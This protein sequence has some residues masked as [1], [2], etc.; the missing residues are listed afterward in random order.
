MVGLHIGWAI[1]I[2]ISLF[3]FSVLVGRW[4]YGA[5][6]LFEKCANF[7]VYKGPFWLN[8]GRGRYLVRYTSK[9]GT[10]K[11]TVDI[12]ELVTKGDGI[13]TGPL[14]AFHAYSAVWR[15]T[16]TRAGR[17]CPRRTIYNFVFGN[18]S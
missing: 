18:R 10:A 9:R 5:V 3:F 8:T 15:V 17:Y 6:L 4:A 11:A 7:F 2:E 12:C 16:C 14:K 1:I 13:C